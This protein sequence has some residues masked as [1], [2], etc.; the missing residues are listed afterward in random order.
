MKNTLHTPT[1][2]PNLTPLRGIAALLTVIFHVDLMLGNG[3]DMLLKVKDSMLFS[4]LYLMVDFFFILSGFVM[5]HVYDRWFSNGVQLTDFKRFTTARFARV[6]PLHLAMLLTVA[7]IFGAS[8][9]VGIPSAPIL[10]TENSL[11]SFITN[12]LLLQ[13]MNLHTWFSWDHAAW[14]ISTEWW[15]Y[16]LFPFLVRPFLRLSRAG[17]VAVVIGCFLGY[18]GITRFILPLVTYPASLPFIHYNPTDNSINVGY[19]FGFLRCLFGFVLGMMM[20]LGYAEN[21]GKTWLAN[22]Y[23]LL[24]LALGLGVC[25]HLAIPDVFTICFL[26]PL[27]LSAAYGSQ[28]TNAL[29]ST[30]PLQRLGDWSFSIYLVHQPLL[31]AIG[32]ILAYG[33]LGKPALPGPPPKPDMLTGWLMCLAFIA[34]TLLVASLTYRFIEVPARQALNARFREQTVTPDTVEDGQ[35]K[36]A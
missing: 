27:L 32:S 14:S 30:K 15:M 18:A 17:R 4:R 35:L 3:G 19:Q 29:F 16:M 6:Y 11:Y 8:A 33:S 1:Y 23:T 22:G 31:F 9:W 26:P 24:A 21:W 34:L 20:H 36:S 7:L 10:Q 13:A 2:L 12:L 5:C 28:R 25:M